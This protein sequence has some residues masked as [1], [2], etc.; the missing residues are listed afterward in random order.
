MNDRNHSET[1]R[2]H[3]RNSHHEGGLTGFGGDNLNEKFPLRDFEAP[4]SHA[5]FNSE[6]QRTIADFKPE[7]FFVGQIVCGSKFNPS[8]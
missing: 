6:E 8:E 7:V 2:D 4:P 1:E 5:F 3:T